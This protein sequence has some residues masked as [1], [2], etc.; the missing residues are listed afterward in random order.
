MI[1]AAGSILVAV[2]MVGFGVAKAEETSS[3]AQCIDR[4]RS[5][6]AEMRALGVGPPMGTGAYGVGYDSGPVFPR[7]DELWSL[8]Q[9]ARSLE[10]RGNEALCLELVDQTRTLLDEMEQ[11][12]M[13][14]RVTAP[15]MGGGCRVDTLVDLRVRNTDGENLG[16][17]ED[18]VIDLE[19]GKIDYA[20]LSV[21]GFFDIGGRLFPIP[22][23]A[24]E[25]APDGR[26][27]IL[28]VDKAALEEAPGFERD[29]WPNMEDPEWN[30]TVQD[31]YAAIAQQ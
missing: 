13:V 31:F 1:K 25:T 3:E 21:G 11:E 7:R 18:V 19:D 15:L 2:L 14:S 30:K 29:D 5:L 22:W 10:E 20:L 27:F 26:S 4:L 9:A 23:E 16:H 24:F 17:I 6:D 8:Y 28:P 12:G